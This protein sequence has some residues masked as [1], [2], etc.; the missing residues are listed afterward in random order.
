MNIDKKALRLTR[1]FAKGAPCAIDFKH[2][3]ATMFWPF[4]EN[5][6]QKLNLTEINEL[7]VKEYWFKIHN[8]LVI[9]RFKKGDFNFKKAVD[10]MV[11][12]IEIENQELACI[13]GG[14]V[15]CALDE[16]EF[17]DLINRNKELIKDLMKGAR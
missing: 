4:Y 12:A 9:K 13:H 14:I 15:V 6:A 7:V 16:N 5:I 3:Q 2:I 8:Q 17:E 1:R 11:R 10:C